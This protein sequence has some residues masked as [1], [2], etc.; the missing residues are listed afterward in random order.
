MK[1]HHLQELTIE[2]HL[3]KGSRVVQFLLNIPDEFPAQ[4]QISCNPELLKTISSAQSLRLRFLD[5]AQLIL[6]QTTTCSNITPPRLY[7]LLTVC[8]L[9]RLT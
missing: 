6:H 3:T 2:S 8:D 1:L 9:A 5:P 7:A 4:L